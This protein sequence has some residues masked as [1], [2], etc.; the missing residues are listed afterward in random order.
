MW[1]L[2]GSIRQSIK[3][4]FVNTLV[5]LPSIVQKGKI[6]RGYAAIGLDNPKDK[7]NVGEALRA[8]GCYGA[9]MVAASGNRYKAAKTD[10][11]K[12]YRHLP[13]IEC[14][15]LRNLV[16]FDCVPV[17]VD[18]IEGA[19]P[20]H[21]YKHPERAFYIFGAEDATLGDR[22]IS[23]CRDVIYVPTAHCMNLAA[24]VNVILYD[25]LAKQVSSP[26]PSPNAAANE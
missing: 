10:T 14:D 19:I 9:A 3:S 5:L 25:R 15:D 18:I 8:A 1:L 24:T 26:Q 6:V 4:V 17:A 2:M 22:I 12:A 23:W 13:L 21:E 20:L 16:P 7:L 11:Q